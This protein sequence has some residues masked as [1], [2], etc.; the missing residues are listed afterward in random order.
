MAGRSKQSVSTTTPLT[1]RPR[2]SGGMVRPIFSRR[3]WGLRLRGIPEPPRR[4]RICCGLSMPMRSR[5]AMISLS[6]WSKL[7]PNSEISAAL[8]GRYC[9]PKRNSTT[10]WLLPTI[11][12]AGLH[13]MNGAARRSPGFQPTSFVV[14]RELFDAV[15][16]YD[17]EI[18]VLEDWDLQG[19]LERSRQLTEGPGAPARPI[20]FVNSLAVAHHAR[21]SLVRTIKHSW[22]WGLPSREG[23][24]QK[25]GIA[26][27]RYERPFRRWLTLPGLVW[28]RAR[29]PFH[30]AWRTSPVRTILSAPILDYNP[31][32]MV[33]RRYRWAGPAGR[34][35]ACA[36]LAAGDLSLIVK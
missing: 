8:A 9:C 1:T 34:G 31:H 11:W 22:Y 32:R 33:G 5:W 26:V 24:L 6:G 20:W 14:R 13:G 10:P 15:G 28:M 18:R 29:H 12:L 7:Q 25:S 30:V 16:G 2:S 4:L 17:P 3:G 23:W 27:A 19:R 36:G 35:Y 21:S